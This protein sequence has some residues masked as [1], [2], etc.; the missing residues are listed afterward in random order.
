LSGKAIHPAWPFEQVMGTLRH[1]GF[2]LR[3]VPLQTSRVRRLRQT[4]M[5][6]NVK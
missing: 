6:D 3:I 4:V 1:G 5:K 2:D